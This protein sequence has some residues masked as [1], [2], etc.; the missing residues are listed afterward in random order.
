MSAKNIQYVVAE[1]LTTKLIKPKII[2]N[3][4]FV[5]IYSKNIFLFKSKF[6][7]CFSRNTF[8]FSKTLIIL[9]PYI[10]S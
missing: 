3:Q 2:I 5:T 8:Y 1:I 7:Q 10:D 9:N 4:Q 6:V